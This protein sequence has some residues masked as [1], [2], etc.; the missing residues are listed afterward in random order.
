MYG[1]SLSH[2]DRGHVGSGLGKAPSFGSFSFALP[3]LT[4]S[5]HNLEQEID[6]VPFIFQMVSGSEA[7]AEFTFYLP[8]QKAFCGAELVSRNLHNLYT[9]RE[10]LIQVHLLP[11]H[12]TRPF[13]FKAL[14]TIPSAQLRRCSPSSASMSSRLKCLSLQ[15]SPMSW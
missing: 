10:L 2:D 15:A 9:L 5:E 14:T 3:T 12:L 4:I 11:L 8:E 6:G 1:K 7:P 13:R